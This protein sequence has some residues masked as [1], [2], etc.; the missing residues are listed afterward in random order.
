MALKLVF[1]P[2]TGKLD[3]VNPAGGGTVPTFVDGEIPTDSGDHT[4]YTL[5]HAPVGTLSLFRNGQLMQNLAGTGDYTITGVTI[6][7]LTA[8]NDTDLLL[9]NYRY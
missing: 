9:A 6:T 5:V 8:N 3:W 1:N 7:F 2:F 4:I